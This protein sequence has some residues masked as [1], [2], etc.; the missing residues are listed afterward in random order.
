MRAAVRHFRW[1]ELEDTERILDPDDALENLEVYVGPADGP[2]EERYQIQVCTPAA[3]QR[4]LDQQPWLIG[5]HWLFVRRLVPDEMTSWLCGRIESLHG[6][7]YDDVA[8]KIARIGL[9]EFEDYTES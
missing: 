3:L 9:W 6:D 4:F 1:T 5:R 2:G 7:T 8:Q